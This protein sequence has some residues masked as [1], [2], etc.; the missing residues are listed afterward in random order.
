MPINLVYV[1]AA[2]QLLERG[3]L[4]PAL[5]VLRYLVAIEEG[6]DIPLMTTIQ[7]VSDILTSLQ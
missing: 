2:I 5:I 3:D 7:E 6:E 1:K 4:T